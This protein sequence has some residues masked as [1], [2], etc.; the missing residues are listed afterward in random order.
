MHLIFIRVCFKQEQIYD[1]LQ[2]R[3]NI[4][5]FSK[6]FQTTDNFH[7]KQKLQ[8]VVLLIWNIFKHI[9][10]YYFL[11]GILSRVNCMFFKNI[12]TANTEHIHIELPLNSQQSKNVYELVN[13]GKIY[14]HTIYV[15]IYKSCIAHVLFQ[16]AIIQTLQ[17]WLL[18]N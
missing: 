7:V 2:L 17:Q 5:Y 4:V 9:N 1:T 12:Y 13:L 14:T 3:Y 16:P 6:G 10:I 11:T 8:R 15:C 18:A